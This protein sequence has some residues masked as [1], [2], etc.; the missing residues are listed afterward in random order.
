MAY[1]V[2]NDRRVLAR[3]Q[4]VEEYRGSYEI[5]LIETEVDRG[6]PLV[7]TT[8]HPFLTLRGWMPSAELRVGDTILYSER[9][10]IRITKIGRS[11][12]EQARVYNLRTQAGTYLVGSAG[13]IAADRPV[14]R[15]GLT[16]HKHANKKEV[17]RYAE[18]R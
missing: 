5:L 8:E 7:V 16:S 11:Y 2:H 4:D 14:P 3:V 10:L 18:L 6:R 9:R 17:D 13:L 1:D 12:L 15:L